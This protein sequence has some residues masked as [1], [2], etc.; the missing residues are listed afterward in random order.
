MKYS[1]SNK[2][3]TFGS[4]LYDYKLIKQDRK[5]LS[6]TVTPSLDIILKSPVSADEERTEAF[7]K[8]KWFWLE[9]Q[10]QYFGKY[11]RRTYKKEYV[12]GE[13]FHYLGR[14]YQL[15]I[16]HSKSDNVGL[17]KGSLIV[18]T[19]KK[20]ENKRYNKKLLESWFE[21]RRIIIFQERFKEM[22]E[23]FNYKDFPKLETREMKK[24]WG[25]FV[26]GNKIV[27]N[28]KLIHLP[29][30]TIDYV[31]THELCHIR[32]R[33]HDKKY[34]KFLDKM[35]SGWELVKEKLETMGVFV[36]S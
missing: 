22:L 8:R 33:N 16:K 9:R 31:I 19:T 23:K 1:K 6:L 32:Y 29:K 24:R 30:E 12:A 5:S 28:P 11:Q 3:F 18:E 36:N 35:Y 34:F 17:I 25:S 7:L 26:N 2:Q 14:Q 4:L 20:V 21:E 27:L 13:S 15:I 10:L